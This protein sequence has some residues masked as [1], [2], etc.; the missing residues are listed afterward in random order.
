[1]C[2][3]ATVVQICSFQCICNLVLQLSEWCSA[4]F[5]HTLA[6]VVSSKAPIISAWLAKPAICISSCSHGDVLCEKDKVTWL[7]WKFPWG[8][9]IQFG[10]GRWFSQREISLHCWSQSWVFPGDRQKIMRTTTC[11]RS[12]TV[13]DSWR[14]SYT[15]GGLIFKTH[16]PI[17]LKKRLVQGFEGNSMSAVN[18]Q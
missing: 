8:E 6:Y 1:M 17:T 7:F 5:W 10:W 16:F 14:Q 2:Q 9:V 12:L 4:L 15:K 11:M 18:P 13:T 3:S